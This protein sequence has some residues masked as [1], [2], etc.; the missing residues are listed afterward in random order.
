MTQ[1]EQPHLVWDPSGLEDDSQDT[2]QFEWEWLCDEISEFMKA[3]NPDSSW[4]ARVTG[5]GWRNLD[6]EAHFHAENGGKLLSSVLPRTECVFK[7]WLNKDK[8]TI[9]ID[10]AHHDKPAGGEIYRI[11]PREET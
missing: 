3:V 1:E 5:F 2:Y 8:K 6:G 9:T 7:V 11:T 10:N 4:H